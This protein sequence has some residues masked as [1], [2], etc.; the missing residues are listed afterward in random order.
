MPIFLQPCGRDHVIA[1]QTWCAHLIDVD[2]GTAKRVDYPA[3]AW[4]VS[5]DIGDEPALN[6]Y[7]ERPRVLKRCPLN[8][9]TGEVSEG[10]I[11]SE[12]LKFPAPHP[13]NLV[14][15]DGIWF[16][17]S[18]E[19]HSLV[20]AHHSR[21]TDLCDDI[22]R[23]EPTD[24]FLTDPDG[25]VYLHRWDI[26]LL[27]PHPVDQPTLVIN[28]RTIGCREPR[29]VAFDKDGV[30]WVLDEAGPVLFEV[31]MPSH[32]VKT[33]NLVP[34]HRESDDLSDPSPYPWHSCIWC[35]GRLVIGC[36]D[37]ARIDIL[38]PTAG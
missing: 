15:Y 32:D 17:H 26:G 7:F 4:N 12:K 38:R 23:I 1:L 31:R 16:A 2:A 25:K 3:W 21:L 5:S 34:L 27:E 18:G 33:H 22:S 10:E 35:K 9:D 36:C 11:I 13:P 14:S 20:A 24:F 28:Y 6:I 37:A 19:Q 29:G 8:V 30:L